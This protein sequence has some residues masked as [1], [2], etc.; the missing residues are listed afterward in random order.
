M[1]GNRLVTVKGDRREVRLR[2]ALPAKEIMRLTNKGQLREVGEEEGEEEKRRGSFKEGVSMEAEYA[3]AKAVEG[4]CREAGQ[5]GRYKGAYMLNIKEQMRKRVQQ[6]VQA[7]SRVRVLTIGAS[8][9]GRIRKE[10]SR[11]G[12]GRLELGEE[13]RVRGV[14]DRKEGGRVEMELEKV[15]VGGTPDKVLIGGPGNSLLGHGGPGRRKRMVERVVTVKRDQEGKVVG[16]ETAYHLVEPVKL[17]M[18]ERKQVAGVVRGLVRKCRELWPMADIFYLEMFPRHVNVCCSA[19][20][21]MGNLDPQ[22]LH[23]SRLELESDILDELRLVGESVGVLNWYVGEDSQPSVEN[24]RQK[25]IVGPDGVHM[26]KKHLESL[27][28]LIFR[29]LTSGEMEGPLEKRRRGSC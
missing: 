23:A 9:V 24:I 27:A 12:D 21:H 10:W 18:C 22:V 11:K 7:G 20:G 26:A 25:G 19:K 2:R 13:I 8:E 29:R 1:R 3:F 14:L 28:G 4:F 15:P 6:A 17:T 5:A 16:M